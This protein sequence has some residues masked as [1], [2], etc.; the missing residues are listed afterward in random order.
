M[1]SEIRSR[2]SSLSTLRLLSTFALLGAVALLAFQLVRYS[3]FRALLPPGTTIGGVPVGGLTRQ[4]AAERLTEVFNQ[5]VE[6]RYND[7]I[8]HL[9]PQTIGFKLD[10]D[11]M[12]A[13]VEQKRQQ[14]PFWQGFWD[15]L[16]GR[17]PPTIHVPLVAD[18]SE[19]RLRAY[20]QQEVAARYDRP[21]LPPQPVVGTVKFR[22]GQRGVA[23]DV[24]QALSLVG[25]AFFSPTHRVV[26]LPLRQTAPPQPALYNLKVLLQ[27]TLKV[28]GFDGVAGVYLM[29]L[30]TGQEFYFVVNNGREVPVPPDVA[31]TAASTIKIPIM[32][33][34]FRRLDGNHIRPEIDRWLKE[35]ID[36]S[37]NGP[38]DWLME[39]VVN[40]ERGP[41]VVT[42]DMR[43][44][45]LQNTFLAGYFYPGAPL[46]AVF[47]TPANQRPD[48]TT[49]PDPYN[50]TTPAEM[51]TL[52]AEI[53]K[54]G[55]MGGGALRAAFPDEITQQE[56]RQMLDL[57]SRNAIG[58]LIQAGVPE[59]TRV[60]H[61]HG[62]ITGPDGAIHNIMDAG[63]VYTPGGNYVLSVYLYRPRELLWDYGSNLL[64]DLSEAAYNFFNPPTR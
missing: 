28:K 51:G 59:G 21:A 16:W 35:M 40:R 15:F 54:C 24:D 48:V 8:I 31:F 42:K 19:S 2:R 60:A 39:N 62:W 32:V 5:P 29:D 25:R 36:Q 20:L 9:Q 4:Q 52:L 23:L 3:R 11:T 64:A 58:V 1:Y 50:Q 26:E 45:G 13:A 30:Q 22:P 18:Y 49:N 57:L 10:I 53:Y 46:L 27:Q 7:A 63:I 55:E 56:C 61:K 38:S 41:L 12:L 6:L 17:M 33:S 34:V 14:T 47:R 44:L 37:G 43:T